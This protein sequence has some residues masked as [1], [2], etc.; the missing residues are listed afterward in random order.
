MSYRSAYL[1]LP[2]LLYA[3]SV[4]AATT[5]AANAVA[6]RQLSIYTKVM[7]LQQALYDGTDYVCEMLD[8]IQRYADEEKIGL[9]LEHS[10]D[11]ESKTGT[12][13]PTSTTASVST[14]PLRQPYAWRGLLL[15]KPRLYLRLVLHV[16]VAFCEGSP[17]KEHDFPPELRRS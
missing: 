3:L 17:P 8:N 4:K 13:T 15:R 14:K 16:D 12:D 6:H 7:K 1:C 2:L 10:Q 5:E 9:V 11:K